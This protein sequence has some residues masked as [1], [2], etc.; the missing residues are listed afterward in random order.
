MTEEGDKW[1]GGVEKGSNGE[2]KLGVG[3]F[4]ILFK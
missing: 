4:K 1:G 3:L 2:G